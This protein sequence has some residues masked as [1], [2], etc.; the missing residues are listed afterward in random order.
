M[1]MDSE[2]PIYQQGFFPMPNQSIIIYIIISV[3]IPAC[4]AA[5]DK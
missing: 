2:F 4:D 3:S 1:R 5:N